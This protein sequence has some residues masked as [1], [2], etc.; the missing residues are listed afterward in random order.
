MS[1]EDMSK[2]DVSENLSSD[3]EDNNPEPFEKAQ[4]NSNSIKRSGTF[5]Q[6][7]SVM[8]DRQKMMQGGSARLL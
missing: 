3:G 5:L 6:R 7:K 2:D 4:D 1:K 8:I